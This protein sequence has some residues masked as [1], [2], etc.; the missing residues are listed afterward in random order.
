[1][2]IYMK[3]KLY[4][5]CMHPENFGENNVIIILTPGACVFILLDE[6]LHVCQFTD[7]RFSSAVG[8]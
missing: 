5:G 1:M 4:F 3:L 2:E 6:K 7:N 8:Q